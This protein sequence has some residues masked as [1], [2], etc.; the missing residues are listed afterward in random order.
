MGRL[1]VR[2]V[3]HR[4]AL[5]CALVDGARSLVLRGRGILIVVAR[6]VARPVGS[7]SLVRTF[8]VV[9]HDLGVVHV[10]IGRSGVLVRFV[11]MRA[12]VVR[13]VGVRFEDDLVRRELVHLGGDL[14]VVGLGSELAR[15]G[16]IVQRGEVGVIE[17][18]L[19]L[20]HVVVEIVV[21]TGRRQVDTDLRGVSTEDRDAG[22]V[23]VP[24]LVEHAV[25]GVLVGVR[26]GAVGGHCS[27]QTGRG[28]ESAPSQATAR[29]G[30]PAKDPPPPP[31]AWYR[32]RHGRPLPRPVP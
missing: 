12:V 32:S 3:L 24:A 19:V 14:V 16:G 22:R 30:S 6:I 8:G 25:L 4:V 23:E 26:V 7:R 18:D 9:A 20:D 5:G 13:V 29:G 17:G 2:L 11:S 21:V 27:L 15:C 10:V 31:A 28:R 1:A